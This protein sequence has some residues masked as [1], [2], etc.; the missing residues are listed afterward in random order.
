[1]TPNPNG[2]SH[3]INDGAK[4]QQSTTIIYMTKHADQP[5]GVGLQADA[6]SEIEVTPAMIEAGTAVLHERFP[7]AA[8]LWGDD[9]KVV[10]RIFRSMW[11]SSPARDG[12][13][14]RAR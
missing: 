9:E 13:P 14:A 3:Q 12:S 4:R 5:I 11:C 6:E 7:D 10:L 1:M 2:R 8:F